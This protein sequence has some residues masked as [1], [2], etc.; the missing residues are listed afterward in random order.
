MRSYP[1]LGLAGIAVLLVAAACAGDGTG[2]GNGNGNGNNDPCSAAADPTATFS[3]DVQPVFTASCALTGCHVA[4]NPPHGLI[5]SPGAAYS[6]LVDVTS[7]EA[8]ALKR[9][10]PGLPDSS[11]LVHKIQGT[12]ASVGGSGGRMPLNGTALSQA[13]IDTIRSWVAAGAANN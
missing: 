1:S 8:P 6:N 3:C 9:I 2:L 10:R 13:V 5:L 4:P 11:Y 7:G 12:Q